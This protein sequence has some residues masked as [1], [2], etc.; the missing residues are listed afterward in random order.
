MADKKPILKNYLLSRIV[1]NI[2][3]Y[4]YYENDLLNPFNAL[5]LSADRQEH[6]CG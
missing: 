1:D 5:N 3:T 2:K 4:G 6:S